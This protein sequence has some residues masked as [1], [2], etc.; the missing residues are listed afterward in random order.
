MIEVNI[1]RH[2]TPG[3][4]R[5]MSTERNQQEIELQFVASL[6]SNEVSIHQS[7]CV[8]FLNYFISPSVFY[9]N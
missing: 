7:N 2:T 3:A 4:R 8:T 5:N 6:C 9:Y 1:K